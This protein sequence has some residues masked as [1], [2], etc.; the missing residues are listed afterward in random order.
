M[1]RDYPSGLVSW[2][3]EFV[4]QEV[5]FRDRPSPVVVCTA[6]EDKARQEYAMSAD[7][8]YQIQRFG[9]GH[10]LQGGAIDFDNLDLTRAMAL[11]EEASEA[12]LRLPSVV[13]E[14]Y[15]SWAAVEAAARSGELDQVLKAAGV[16]AGRSGGTAAASASDSAP[17]SG[18]E[19]V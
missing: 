10:P 18:A 7:I 9:V 19:P 17:V 2:P 8:K 14:R 15:Q 13:R 5:V 6:E 12:W 3:K 11:V 16:P 1:K 4:G